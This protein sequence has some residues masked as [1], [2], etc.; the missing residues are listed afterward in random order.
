MRNA[1]RIAVCLHPRPRTFSHFLANFKFRAELRGAKASSCLLL[2]RPY[3]SRWTMKHDFDALHVL[4]VET[5]RQ[6]TEDEDKMQGGARVL[7]DFLESR[8]LTFIHCR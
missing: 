1:R 5:K 6:K 4:L 8:P 3:V 2:V 7:R